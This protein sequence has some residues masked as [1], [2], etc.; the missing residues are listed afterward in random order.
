[1]RIA[2]NVGTTARARVRLW[3]C[4]RRFVVAIAR[5]A[6]RPRRRVSLGAALAGCVVPGACMILGA[7]AH[8]DPAPLLPT[9]TARQFDA[10]RLGDDAVRA[11]VTRALPSAAQAPAAWPPREWDRA[12]LLAVALSLNPRLAVAAAE[13][14]ATRAHE[15][16]VGEPPN[17]DLVLQS[18]YAIH[19][20]HPW[21]Y[22]LSM[23][24]L[25]RS[26][27]RQ[28]DQIE[29]AR[30]ETGTSRLTF[31]DEIWTVRKALTAAL[32]DAEFAGRRAR[33]L[34]ELSGA[35]DRHVASLRRRVAAGEDP[36]TELV[37]PETERIDTEQ[38][39]SD[40]RALAVRAR[41][42][43][44]LTLGLPAAAVDGLVVNWDDWGA[45]APVEGNALDDQRERALLSR[46][47]LGAL[48]GE[49]AV[50]EQKLRLAITRQYP[51]I[52]LEPGY[53]WDHGIA[54]WPFDLGFTLPLNGNKGEIGEA[55]AAR[56]LAARRMLALQA[57]IDTELSAAQHAE[58]VDREG[59]DLARRRVDAASGR[60]S[61]AA[62]GVSRGEL[63][64]RARLEA[65]VVMLRAELEL[66]DAEARL[67]SA[68]NDLEHALRAPL[69]GP[70]LKLDIV[71]AGLSGAR[72]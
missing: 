68:R 63:D 56:E 69:S 49:Y 23:G 65:E 19:D 16:T 42:A 59:V 9:E 64:G 15:T 27:G 10:R 52:A 34:Q 67:Q 12:E 28:R 7:C 8:Y 26:P 21:L 14:G 61:M 18:E 30:L 1:M 54:K 71:G 57:E 70:E 47:D 51:G 22:G 37:T 46:P 58:V 32:S 45:P 53:Y 40:A 50:A 25:L 4:R 55:R 31:M 5:L 11:A 2:T 35:E 3:S 39:L 66:L 29:L 38:Q 36:R 20:Q 48:I 41:A 6:A 43:L 17:P 13:W 62:R 33:L 60:L 44:A 24:W 72:S